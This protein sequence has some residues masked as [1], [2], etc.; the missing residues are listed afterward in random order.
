M[1]GWPTTWRYDGTLAAG[2]DGVP[3]LTFEE[4]R[5]VIPE[6]AEAMLDND[7]GRARRAARVKQ[8]IDDIAGHPE[9]RTNIPKVHTIGAGTKDVEAAIQLA[10]FKLCAPARLTYG[11]AVR[12]STSVADILRIWG[13]VERNGPGADCAGR[14][15]QFRHDWLERALDEITAWVEFKN[16]WL[17]I[18][19]QRRS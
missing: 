6:L 8:L 2:P 18:R 1:S 4:Y 19:E 9:N 14:S 11:G 10:A 17:Q 7:E 5:R 13:P 16:G 15:M 3:T 12:E